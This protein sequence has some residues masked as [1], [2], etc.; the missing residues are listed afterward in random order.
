L[1]E[2]RSFF[3]ITSSVM[4]RILVDRARAKHAA[5]RSGSQQQANL[6]EV[7][8]FSS[9]QPEDVTANRSRFKKVER[10]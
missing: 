6:D 3:A 2:P 9:E 5:K 1:A 10:D 8:L 7:V 4:R